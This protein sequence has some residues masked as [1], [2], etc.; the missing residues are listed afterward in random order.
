MR[1]IICGDRKWEHPEP[2]KELLERLKEEHGTSL[3]VITGAAKGA[4]K[5]ASAL[6]IDLGIDQVICPANWAGRSFS[7]GA[8]RNA[9]M[10][11][12]ALAFGSDVEVH[13]FHRFISNSK[14]TK[15]MV[16]RAKNMGVKTFVHDQVA[17]HA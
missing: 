7:A 13:A 17:V 12:L 6:C 14:G 15:N 4:D 11:R 2:I 3:L 5:L 9:L 10:L 1:V 8:I 16:D